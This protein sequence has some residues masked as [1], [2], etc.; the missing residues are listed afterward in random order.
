MTELLTD[1]LQKKPPGNVAHTPMRRATQCYSI[2]LKR[3]T[4]MIRFFLMKKNSIS[5]DRNDGRDNNDIAPESEAT[6]SEAVDYHRM[7]IMQLH[8]YTVDVTNHIFLSYVHRQRASLCIM[9][10]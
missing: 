10:T 3:E 2:G 9:I 5:N 1:N 7:Q 4:V 6:V 8:L